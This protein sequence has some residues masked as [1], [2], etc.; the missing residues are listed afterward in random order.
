METDEHL[1]RSFKTRIVEY[2]GCVA[3]ANC[4]PRAHGGTTKV[5][6]CRCG[7]ER[8]MN[9]MGNHYEQ[10]RWEKW[11]RDDLQPPEPPEFPICI[12]WDGQEHGAF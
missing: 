1:H 10:G 8:L 4:N 3:P 5:S 2:E 6:Y 12:G 9:A 11:L 7:S